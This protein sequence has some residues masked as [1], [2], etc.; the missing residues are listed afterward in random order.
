[1][2]QWL[3]T[4]SAAIQ[5]ASCPNSGVAP[6][7]PL[8]SHRDVNKTRGALAAA[9]KLVGAQFR[10][11]VVLDVKSRFVNSEVC[12][13]PWCVQASLPVSSSTRC[14]LGQDLV[15]FVMGLNSLGVEVTGV[16]S[17]NPKKVA[18]FRR[19]PDGT[20]PFR[21]ALADLRLPPPHGVVF[22]HSAEDLRRAC[23]YVSVVGCF[24]L[25]ED[26]VSTMT[27]M[28]GEVPFLS[29]PQLCSTWRPLS[30]T[31]GS[32]VAPS[33]GLPCTYPNACL[34]TC[35]GTKPAIHSV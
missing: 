2:L 6:P 28:A 20:A 13:C 4:F 19:S 25:Y 22:F 7:M 27:S 1:M 9:T 18:A 33:S 31:H 29:T 10:L 34:T 32:A 16:G 21:Q 12:A 3:D 35:C 17:F 14:L 5:Q 30:A 15:G 8:P 23:E 11:Q 24:T 26:I